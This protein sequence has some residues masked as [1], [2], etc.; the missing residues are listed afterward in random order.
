VTI[1]AS[2][3]VAIIGLGYVGLTLATSLADVGLR[4]L[5]SKCAE[6]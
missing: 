6:T 2:H 1:D 4:V 5:G 3:D